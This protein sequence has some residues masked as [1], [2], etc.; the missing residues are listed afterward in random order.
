MKTIILAGGSGTRLFPL[1]RTC[2]PKQFI[3]LLGKESLFQRSVRRALLFSRP[4]E[5]Y[6]ITSTAHRFLVA[7][8]LAEIGAPCRVLTEPEGKNTLP[9][10]AYGM[11]TILE[12]C[13]D[14]TVAVLSSDQ[15]IEGGDAYTTTFRAA[16]GLVEE[17]LV[18]TIGL[19][20]LAVV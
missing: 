9:A 18:T 11:M 10:I 7:D 2:Y 5:I 1:S 15:L 6:V 17:H 13:G 12:E 19:S 4:E 8:Q 20:D 3:P 16:E 14:D